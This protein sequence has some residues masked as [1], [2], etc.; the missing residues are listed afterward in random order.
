MSFSTVHGLDSI[1]FSM[2]VAAYVLYQVYHAIKAR[3]PLKKWVDSVV[4]PKFKQE[5]STLR[6]LERDMTQALKNIAK[7][8]T[9]WN[10]ENQT[11]FED[12]LTAERI[13]VRKI[14]GFKTGPP[15][16][17]VTPGHV[18]KFQLGR[19]ESEYPLPQEPSQWNIVRLFKGQDWEHYR[20]DCIVTR[21]EY[22]IAC[23]KEKLGWLKEEFEVIKG[24]WQY[25]KLMIASQVSSSNY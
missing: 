9:A 22:E 21:L 20:L 2:L 3:N 23:E 19:K 18:Y 4:G 8:I 15:R 17:P 24:D 1:L 5:A 12:I 11:M 7:D 6:M 10:L 14:R 16:T 13:V 25:S